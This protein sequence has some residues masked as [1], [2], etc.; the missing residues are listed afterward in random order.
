[1]RQVKFGPKSLV[2]I[3]F[4]VRFKPDITRYENPSY[5]ETMRIHK[6]NRV[7]ELFPRSLL[8]GIPTITSHAKSVVEFFID[9]V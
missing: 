9:L 8:K 1:M 4:L 5:G 7:H 3:V 6:I 2:H